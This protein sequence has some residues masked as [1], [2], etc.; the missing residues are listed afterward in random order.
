VPAR[1]TAA[2]ILGRGPQSSPGETLGLHAG[3]N[4]IPGANQAADSC[5]LR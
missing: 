5:V 1:D 3:N 4:G 2:D